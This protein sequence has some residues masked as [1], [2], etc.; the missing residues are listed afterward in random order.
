M[1]PLCYLDQLDGPT[2]LRL[3][4]SFAGNKTSMTWQNIVY[5]QFPAEWKPDNPTVNVK[6]DDGQQIKAKYTIYDYDHEGDPNYSWVDENFDLLEFDPIL[7]QRS[8]T[9]AE[10]MEGVEDDVQKSRTAK[11]WQNY[12][13]RR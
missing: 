7:W 6:G 12:R 10:Y 8:V 13:R 2:I 3:E 11:H 9:V 1:G 4:V 5:G